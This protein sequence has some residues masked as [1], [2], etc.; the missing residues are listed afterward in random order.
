MNRN[1]LRRVDLN[2]LIVFETLMH[3]RSVTRA[4]EKLFLGQPAISAALS[5]L[6]GLI[7]DPLFVRT[8]RSMEPT[9]RATEI[10]GLLSPALDCI[11]PPVG[12]ASAFDP[13]TTT[14]VFRFC[15][16]CDVAFA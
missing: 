13:A 10:F 5:R 4:A 6:R 8:G 14:S 9:A 7:D 12:R 16:S 3:E 11:S 15:L 1:D 2:L